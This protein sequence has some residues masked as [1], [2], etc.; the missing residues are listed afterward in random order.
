MS[1]LTRIFFF[2]C[3]LLITGP[4][5]SLTLSN[6][7]WV[8]PPPQKLMTTVPSCA[9][10]L[11]C[12]RWGGGTTFQLIMVWMG[13]WYE[14]CEWVS[15]TRVCIM[16]QLVEVWVL[17]YTEVPAV[18]SKLSCSQSGGWSSWLPASSTQHSAASQSEMSGVH[19]QSWSEGPWKRW[20]L[21]SKSSPAWLV[22]RWSL[23]QYFCPLEETLPSCASSNVC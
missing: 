17:Q 6:A 4:E 9:L 12:K 14:W 18:K 2:F 22:A 10:W 23:P 3:C 21:Q 13:E 5:A 1:F 16:E 11:P 7:L 8:S 15:H 20:P 19:P